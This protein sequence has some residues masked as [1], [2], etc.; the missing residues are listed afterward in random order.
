MRQLKQETKIDKMLLT[1]P[2]VQLNDKICPSILLFPETLFP[3]FW[4]TTVI[5]QKVK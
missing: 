4:E 5:P 3:D 2:H 1:S